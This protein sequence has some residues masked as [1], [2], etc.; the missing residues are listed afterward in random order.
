MSWNN[1]T[2][3]H[4][5]LWAAVP[6]DVSDHE[7]AVAKEYK[8]IPEDTSRSEAEF[9]IKLFKRDRMIANPVIPADYYEPDG[10]IE[11]FKVK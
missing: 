9:L 1:I 5:E 6:G 8:M 11:K 7:I 3:V 2:R 10:R 4:Q